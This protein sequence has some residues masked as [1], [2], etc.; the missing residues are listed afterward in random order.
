MQLKLL[1]HTK[2]TQYDPS[3]RS[4]TAQLLSGIFS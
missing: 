3:E 1:V 2:F 4:T